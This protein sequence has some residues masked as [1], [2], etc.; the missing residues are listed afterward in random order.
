VK[1]ILIKKKHKKYFLLQRNNYLT[2]IQ[3]KI[4]KIFGRYLFTNF[5]INF[6]NPISKI[7]YKLNNEFESEFKQLIKYLPNKVEN[8]ADIGCGLGIINILINNHFNKKIYFTLI[9]S[10][11]IERKV[12]YGFHPKGQFYNSFKLTSDLLIG[13]GIKK[14]RLNLVDVD[15][16]NKLKTKF[17]LVISLLSMGYH[18]PITQYLKFFIKNT[19]KETIFIFD[20]ANEHTKFE[21]ISKIFVSTQI[22]K[23]SSEIRHN[24][25]RICCKGLIKNSI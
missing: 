5:F 23:H 7:N 16:K 2:S 1:K 14:E 9:D 19:H 21:E 18:Y 15:N 3:K 25:T 8:V 10:D 20:I 17:D 11:Q 24:Y 12:S 22:I 6:F 4:R 13:N